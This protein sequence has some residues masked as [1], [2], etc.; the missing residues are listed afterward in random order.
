MT[1]H[2]PTRKI[3]DIGEYALIDHLKK[4]ISKVKKSSP[5]SRKCKNT[6]L[7]LGIGDDAALI[8]WA[9]REHVDKK[10]DLLLAISK[11][12]LVEGVHF[13]RDWLS[14]YEIGR[15]SIVSNIS[16]MASMGGAAPRYIVVGLALP[17]DISVD[18]V[19]NLF[20]GMDTEA[21]KVGAVF[22]GGDT[23][24]SNKD[25]VI[26]ITIIGEIEKQ[27]V[28]LRSG[29]TVGDYICVTGP[30]GDSAAGLEI[31]KQSRVN[32]NFKDYCRRLVHKY[33]S[34]SHRLALAQQLLKLSN[35]GIRPNS[36]ID[37]SD[38]LA[39]SVRILLNESSKKRNTS[40]GALIN[41]EDVPLSSPFL[42]WASHK[43]K[44]SPS[45]NF[46]KDFL[47]SHPQ[48][49]WT[50]VLSGG[51]EYELVFT[52]S[53]QNLDKLKKLAKFHIIG[54]VSDSNFIEWNFKGRRLPHFP[55]GLKGYENF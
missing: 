27:K 43:I 13:K 29:A 16:D 19:D 21:R 24:K 48:F 53:P 25:I 9:G 44:T 10:K 32:F 49:P 33:R 26:S 35:Q 11:D 30:F 50:T 51:E 7:L 12:I 55:S 45:Q 54:R 37:S 42:K 46:S 38:G 17:V 40:L 22:I 41:L 36:M 18:N 31:L 52:V 39:A 20:K 15:K 4:L 3:T 2:T 34:P 6:D 23:V 8:R 1:P 14:F 47:F 5:L 28:V